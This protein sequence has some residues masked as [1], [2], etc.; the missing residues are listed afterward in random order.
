[1][2]QGTKAMYKKDGFKV[3]Q[4]VP[5]EDRAKE[6]K[7]LDLGQDKLPVEQALGVC[8]CIESDTL[9]FR[10]Q[11]KDQPCTRR[12]ILGIMSLVYDPLGF[13]APVMLVGKKILQD[14]CNTRDWNE[15]LDE[16]TRMRWK[17]WRDKLFLLE[18]M[19]VKRSLKPP[20]FGKVKSAQLHTMS[21]A[22]T[23][24]YGQCSYLRLVDEH[25]AIHVS[26][27]MGKARIAPKKTVSIPRLE[28]AAATVSAK[29]TDAL[30][31]ELT[32]EGLQEYYWTDSKVVL[33]YISNESK[34]FHVYVGCKVQVA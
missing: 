13:I 12:G 22:S 32:Y 14:I 27:L 6:M 19:K 16:M 3:L 7:G 5:E 15:P 10:I 21:D 8:W 34:R 17:K 29:M 1:M 26:F 23:I 28:L 4:S 20:E 18:N 31:D 24:G 2:V 11:L 30:K 33:G 9:Q 25:G